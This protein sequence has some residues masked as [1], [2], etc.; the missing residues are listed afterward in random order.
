MHSIFRQPCTFNGVERRA[1][2][3]ALTSDS[4]QGHI[5]YT[6]SATFF[7]HRDESDF[8]VSYDAYTS[9]M[10]FEGAGRRSKK[11][12]KALLAQLHSVIDGLAS[13]M[14][15]SVDWEAPLRPAS[16]G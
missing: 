7:A 11:R 2:L 15:A 4:E 9:K 12:E 13:A 5:T 6:A 10:L 3:V 14:N 1:A 8:A 16:L